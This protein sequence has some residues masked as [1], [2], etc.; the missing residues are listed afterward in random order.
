MRP[1]HRPSTASDA[2]RRAA[3]PLNGN[4]Q[5]RSVAVIAANDEVTGGLVAEA[6][7]RVGPDGIVTV[8]YGST[9]ETQLDVLD[10]MAFDCGYL[11]HHM[12]THG[13]RSRRRGCR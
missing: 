8:D 12:V 13:A 10:G 11:S 4:G 1:Q 3:K 6:L 5:I 2:L 9:V 7:E